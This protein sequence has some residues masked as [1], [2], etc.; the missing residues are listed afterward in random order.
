MI[1]TRLFPK[2]RSSHS[3]ARAVTLLELTIA[4][5]IFALL[6]GG[7]Y[8]FL[9]QAN[10]AGSR[11]FTRQDLVGQSNVIMKQI[12]ED[13]QVAASVTIS[14][15]PESAEIAIVQVFDNKESKVFYTWKKPELIRK[16]NFENR[17]SLHKF[18]NNVEKFLVEKKLRP[19]ID[20]DD[21]QAANEQVLVELGLSSWVP[22]D[23]KPL[24]HEQHVMATMRNVSSVKYD[25]HWR[26]VGNLKG[27]FSS[28]G[29]LL[30]SLTEDS[31]LLI[32]DLSSS[33]EALVEDAENTAKDALSQ[34]AANLRQAE[35]QI[36]T[37]LSDLKKGKID[38]N[39]SLND[40][41]S[42]LNSMPSDIFQRE[43][44][45]FGTWFGD[46]GAALRRVQN[47]FL[48]M[49]TVADCDVSRLEAAARPFALNN[50]FRQFLNS[51]REAL[52]NRVKM[53]NNEAKL[54]KLLDDVK[55]KLGN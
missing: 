45:K 10:T 17:T 41:Q 35:V 26:E 7:M 28:Y 25:P 6:M 49:K 37:A 15:N 24:T 33:T 52:A 20:S 9:H 40:M 4:I 32:E 2:E 51:K 21:V 13:F 19:S 16:V 3:N 14:M 53:E 1:K 18:S 44:K 55:S 30:K 11:A 29:D 43:V 12:Q 8:S 46:K 22:G 38:L 50:A 23:P 47:A 36:K 54:G 31:K 42:N 5:L 27:A 34:N 48:N 39:T